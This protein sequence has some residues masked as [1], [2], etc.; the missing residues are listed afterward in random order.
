MSGYS[1]SSYS[2]LENGKTSI[3]DQNLIELLYALDTTYT[4]HHPLVQLILNISDAETIQEGEGVSDN[5]VSDKNIST[6]R[7][8]T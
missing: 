4:I 8:G 3:L 6:R 5:Q 1:I 2:L 7:R